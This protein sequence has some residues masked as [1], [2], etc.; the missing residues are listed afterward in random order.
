M[1]NSARFTEIMTRGQGNKKIVW[2]Y[3][4]NINKI[5]DYQPY[6]DS[7]KSDLTEK[8]SEYTR[9]RPIKF[10]LKLESTYIRPLVENSSNDRSFQTTSNAIFAATNIGTIASEN[11]SKLLADTE[12][13]TGQ[14]SAF[15]L[16]KIDGM[17]LTIYPYTPLE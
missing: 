14:G 16:E 12:E 3:A 4:K 13:Y 17:L 10:H 7:I 5:T 6:L 9:N 11:F 2:F 1:I 15:H 8:L